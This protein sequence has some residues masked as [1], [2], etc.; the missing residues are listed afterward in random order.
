MKRRGLAKNPEYGA[1]REIPESVVVRAIEDLLEGGRLVPKGRKYPTVW[2]PG[3]A[4]RAPRDPA[5]P[6]KPKPV[7]LHAA[8]VAYRRKEAR[9]RRWK[10]YQVLTNDA[11]RRIVVERP[12]IRGDLLAIHGLGEAKVTKFGDA[13]LDLVQEFPS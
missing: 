10:P 3:K 2:L 5:A 11:I 13:I 7:G 4:V 1:L 9:R 8:L 6:A 12:R